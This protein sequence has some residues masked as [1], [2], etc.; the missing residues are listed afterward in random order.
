MNPERPIDKTSNEYRATIKCPC[1]GISWEPLTYVDENTGRM[2]VEAGHTT[3]QT[4]AICA[5]HQPDAPA[6]RPTVSPE[7]IDDAAKA[8]VEL[9]GNKTAE[10]LLGRILDGYRVMREKGAGSTANGEGG[11][12]VEAGE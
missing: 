7:K 2:V 1:C 5:R 9:V 10:W 11:D 8:R 12:H 6:A 4:V 3:D